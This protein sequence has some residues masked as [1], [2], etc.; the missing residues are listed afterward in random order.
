ME[1]ITAKHP[2]VLDQIFQ[3]DALMDAVPH[4]DCAF[5]TQD[6]WDLTVP[7]KRCALMDN[8][9]APAQLA[10]AM[11]EV[12][13]IR[14][15][16][17]ADVTLD[18][19]ELFARSSLAN[20]VCFLTRATLENALLQTSALAIQ[21]GTELIVDNLSAILLASTELAADQT[22]ALVYLVTLNAKDNSLSVGATRTNA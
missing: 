11:E 12:L 19:Q 18:T 22:L 16:R 13:A 20:L 9:F 1:G 2:N 7:L 8:R 21:D 4:Q 6:L 10:P 15:E 14:L 5:A 3:M 17:I